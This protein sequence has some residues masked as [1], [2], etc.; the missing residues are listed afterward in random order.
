MRA[1]FGA[2]VDEKKSDKRV[3]EID[4]EHITQPRDVRVYRAAK[5][6]EQRRAASGISRAGHLVVCD[7]VGTLCYGGYSGWASLSKI[8]H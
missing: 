7:I 2:G 8:S 5:S 1:E 4:M 3:I 6:E